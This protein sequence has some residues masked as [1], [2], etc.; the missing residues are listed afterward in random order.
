MDFNDDG[1]NE[2]ANWLKTKMEPVVDRKHI[3]LYV[4]RRVLGKDDPWEG[5]D[6]SVAKNT[7]FVACVSLELEGQPDETGAATFDNPSEKDYKL[8]RKAVI[9]NMD[10]DQVIGPKFIDLLMGSC[11]KMMDREIVAAFYRHPKIGSTTGR[12]AC[13]LEAMMRVG[14][15]WEGLLPAGS[16]DVFFQKC[17][18]A[19]GK[20]ERYQDIHVGVAVQNTKFDTPPPRPPPTPLTRF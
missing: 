5:W 20:T 19:L 4:R 1:G 13:T 3:I 7:A 17:L 9:V 11:T 15:Y 2:N 10:N 18:S 12:I 14:G 16:Q 6:S 8:L